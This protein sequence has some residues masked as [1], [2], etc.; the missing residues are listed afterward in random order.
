MRLSPNLL[1]IENS[2]LFI[3]LENL[4]P[5][6]IHRILRV[7]YPKYFIYIFILDELGYKK[8]LKMNSIKLLESIK[9]IHPEEI[10]KFNFQEFKRMIL[11]EDP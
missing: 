7:H 3:I 1:L 2:Y 6:Y 5:Q 11:L 8:L 10:Q 4:N 9:V